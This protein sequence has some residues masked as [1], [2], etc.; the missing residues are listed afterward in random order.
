MS[1]DIAVRRKLEI[2]ALAVAMARTCNLASVASDGTQTPDE[3]MREDPV[4]RQEM[5]HAAVAL[6]EELDRMGMSFGGPDRTVLPKL[7]TQLMEA[8]TRPSLLVFDPRTS[9]F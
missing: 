2:E 7:E 1:S 5:R 4:Y 6:Y 8:Y 3:R 9:A